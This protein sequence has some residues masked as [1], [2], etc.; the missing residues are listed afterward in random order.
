[1]IVDFFLEQLTAFPMFLLS[2]L[3][4]VGVGIPDNVFNWLFDIANA[5]GYLLPIKGLLGILAL[6]LT[7]KGVQIGWSILLRVKSFIPMMGA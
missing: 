6:S 2:L 1:M 3:P 4:T 7:I 5:V